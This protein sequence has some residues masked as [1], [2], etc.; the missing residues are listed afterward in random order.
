MKHTH[1]HAVRSL[2]FF[3]QVPSSFPIQLNTN[4]L[5]TI[6]PA[7]KQQY[8]NMNMSVVITP[9]SVPVSVKAGPSGVNASI[10]LSLTFSMYTDIFAECFSN[11]TADLP[12]SLPCP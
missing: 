6:V 1:T 2:L 8:P 10:F 3:Q 5:G 7:L 11:P 4:S 12:S 9:P